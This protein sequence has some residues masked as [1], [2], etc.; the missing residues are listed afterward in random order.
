LYVGTLVDR[1]LVFAESPDSTV[2]S[3][4]HTRLVLWLSRQQ[5]EMARRSALETYTVAGSRLRLDKQEGDDDYTAWQQMNGVFAAT[6]VFP[7]T[8]GMA[9]EAWRVWVHRVGRPKTQVT[10]VLSTEN[11][12]SKI[13]E[14]RYLLGTSYH[15]PGH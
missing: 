9:I 5:T 1:T 14:G 4:P 11:A 7:M 10:H 12:S 3:L 8:V 13:S 15:E 2:S 6:L